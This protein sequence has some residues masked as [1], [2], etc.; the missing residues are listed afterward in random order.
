[1]VRTA[2]TMVRLVSGEYLTGG[3]TMVSLF[4]LENHPSETPP[5]L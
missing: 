3:V 5:Y 4:A 2:L 1:M